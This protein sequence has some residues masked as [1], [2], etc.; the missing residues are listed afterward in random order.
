MKVRK[1]TSNV[2]VI[3]ELQ[4]S[5]ARHLRGILS[6]YLSEY[7]GLNTD[8]TRLAMALTQALKIVRFGGSL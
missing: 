5:E 7:E 2:E 1:S 6:G 8:N 4:E 3:I